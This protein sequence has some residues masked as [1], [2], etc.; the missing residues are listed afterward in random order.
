MLRSAR[1]IAAMPLVS[2][3]LIFSWV[4]LGSFLLLLVQDKVHPLLVF[5]LELYL[6][7]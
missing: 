6:S 5:F 3:E 7:A 1:R 2:T 4:V